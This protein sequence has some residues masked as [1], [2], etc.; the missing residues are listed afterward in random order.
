MRIIHPQSLVS[1]V[2]EATVTVGI[3]GN[4]LVGN[5]CPRAGVVTFLWDVAAIL[6]KTVAFPGHRVI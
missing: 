3:L 6:V 1:L 4:R 5:S 2:R